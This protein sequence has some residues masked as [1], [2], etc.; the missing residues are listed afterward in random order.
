MSPYSI[1]A[2]YLLAALLAVSTSVF[3]LGLY[4]IGLQA[5]LW[6][7]GYFAIDGTASALLEVTWLAVQRIAAA[8]ALVQ[9]ELA[10]IDRPLRFLG[11]QKSF[12]AT[13]V[14]LFIHLALIA[15]GVEVQ[16]LGAAFMLCATSTL[17]TVVVLNLSRLTYCGAR[18]VWVNPP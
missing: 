18:S 1:V 2:G 11:S 10:A 6:I 12:A 8:L 14:V 15:D 13:G 5:A 7:A 4:S 9:S 3:T 17:L 16:A